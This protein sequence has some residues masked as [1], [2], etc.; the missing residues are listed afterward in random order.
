MWSCCLPPNHRNPDPSGKNAVFPLRAPARRPDGDSP[1]TSLL[2]GFI[3]LPGDIPHPADRV[4]VPVEQVLKIFDT[5]PCFLNAGHAFFEVWRFCMPAIVRRGKGY[6][7]LGM[8]FQQHVQQV[9]PGLVPSGL[10][11]RIVIHVVLLIVRTKSMIA[12]N[13]AEEDLL[14]GGR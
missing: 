7:P 8:E 14:P 11:V 12:G 10:D 13:A 9:M 3:H 1:E 4:L 5:C 2:T 6:V